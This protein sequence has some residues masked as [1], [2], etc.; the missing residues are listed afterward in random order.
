M[1]LEY[2]NVHVLMLMQA[3]L[4]KVTENIRN[5]SIDFAPNVININVLLEKDLEKTR[6]DVDDIL[7]AFEANRLR[8]YTVDLLVK[9][10]ANIV[11]DT[12]EYYNI[13]FPGRMVYS[14]KEYFL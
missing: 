5:V 12:R 3:L 10:T 9:V 8:D 13:N 7:F 6:E 1:D 14:R 4:G 11:I 2:E